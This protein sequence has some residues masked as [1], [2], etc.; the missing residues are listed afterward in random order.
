LTL[1]ATVNGI[2]D[3]GGMH[4][5]GTIQYLREE[6]PFRKEWEGRMFAL[7]ATVT[8][9]G[10]MNVEEWRHGMERMSPAEYLTSSY[11]E[12]WLHSVVDLL[13]QKGIMSI[14][15][16]EERMAQMK[17]RRRTKDGPDKAGRNTKAMLRKEMVAGALAAGQSTRSDVAIEPRFKVGQRVRAKNL[18]S[19][20]HTRLV[21][22]VRGKVGVV[23]ADFGVFTLP[24]TM[25]HG[26][27]PTPQHVYSIAF[28]SEELWGPRANPQNSSRVGLWED[29]LDPVR[30]EVS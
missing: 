29:Y 15:D 20:G 13:D 3:M 24:D 23:E 9:V 1:E 2:H 19:L 26:N 14:A 6:P 4:G 12:H 10:L 17:R 21:R 25:A 8:G 11:Y 30:D 28:A 16:L 5:F 27:V 18:Q 7:L 22:Y